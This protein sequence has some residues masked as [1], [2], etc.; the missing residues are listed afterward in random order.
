M[1]RIEVTDMGNG[2]AEVV[3]NRPEKHNGVDWAMLRAWRRIPHELARDRTIRAVVLRGEGPSFCSGLDFGDFMRRPDR[4]LRA[5]VPTGRTNLAQAAVWDWRDLPFPVI[6]ALHGRCYGGGLQLALAADFRIAAPDCELSVME[7]RWGLIPDMSGTLALRELVG[8]DQA[9][10]LSMTA[11]RLSGQQA[12]AIGL[13]TEVA[14]DPV[15]AAHALATELAAKSPDAVSAC[16]RLLQG[17]WLA[18][19]G[20]AL[21]RERRLQTPLLLGR[22]FREALRANFKKRLPRFADRSPLRWR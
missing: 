2:I 12:L 11:R 15:E 5:F 19:E 17:N 3:L 18:Q 14:D 8:I 16:K 1:K 22:N 10:L 9:K 13:V 6:A 4:I 21:G 7:G 20:E